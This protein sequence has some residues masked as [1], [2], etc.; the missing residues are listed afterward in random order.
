MCKKTNNDIQLKELK[1][2]LKVDGLICF[3]AIRELP[4]HGKCEL[5]N[6]ANYRELLHLFVKNEAQLQIHL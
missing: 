5:Q 4:F 2:S 3:L 1:C 6:S